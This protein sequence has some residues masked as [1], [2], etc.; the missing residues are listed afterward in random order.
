MVHTSIL[1][2]EFA[3]EAAQALRRA[4]QAA[5]AAGHSVV[6]ID[7]EARYVEERPNGQLFEIRFDP[8]QTGE[9]HRIIV[10]ELPPANPG[11]RPLAQYRQT[12]TI[13]K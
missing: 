9:A 2:D 6:F 13:A 5:L 8:T 7:A 3:K 4:R 10:R 12:M 1:T 11:Q